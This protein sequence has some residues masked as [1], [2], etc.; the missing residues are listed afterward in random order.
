MAILPPMLQATQEDPPKRGH[1]ALHVLVAA[2]LSA[3]F[4]G[5]YQ[6]SS[7]YLCGTDPY[8]HV[9][10][11]QLIGEGGPILEFPWAQWSSWRDSFF[12]KEVLYHLY[13][14]LFVRGDMLAGAKVANVILGVGIFS[15]FMWILQKNRMRW[16]WLWWFL[17]LSSGG[18]FLFRMNVSRPQVFSVLIL[19][20]GLHVL[21]NERHYLVGALSLVYSL[22]YTGH[23]QYVGLCVG[24]AG[25]VY[26]MERRIPWRV[27]VFALGGM[28]LGWVVH[29]NFPHNV[30]GFWLQ[31]IQVIMAHWAP[32]VDLSMGGELNPMT[33]RS[34]LGVNGATLIP[35]WVAFS[36]ALLRRPQVTS[37]TAFLFAASTLYLIMTL[38]TKRFAEYWIPVTALFHASFYSSLMQGWDPVL[39]VVR[40]FQDRPLVGGLVAVLVFPP[41][42]LWALHIGLCRKG[43]WARL[44][45]LAKTG[46]VLAVV[47]LVVGL[48]GLFVASHLDSF[49]QVNRC[50]EP[51]YGPSAR[52]VRDKIPEGSQVLTCD[53]DDA[54]YL[55]FFSHRHRYTVFLDPNFMYAWR[56]EVWHR[57]NRLAHAKDPDPLGTLRDY[58]GAEYVYCT[59]DFGAFRGQLARSPGATQ[60]YPPAEAQA[61][62]QRCI[63]HRDC[64][65]CDGSQ[66]C[67]EGMICK[68]PGP[69]NK[70]EKR[71]PKRCE[72]D[73]HAY[74][75]QVKQ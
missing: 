36:L 28:L 15:L 22:S 75:F 13:L 45:S 41:N 12:D 46:G 2:I 66:D 62:H 7:T 30:S 64:R 55:F 9:K 20:G 67:P 61:L 71:Q 57:W 58:F 53:W 3:V 60:L 38:F 34:L 39:K 49:R 8:Y 26:L 52:F 6:F 1:L 11:S 24:Y 70:E 29:P 74:I 68:H 47:A 21:M 50:E 17:L 63:G 23:Y 37:R 43:R 5:Y 16:A 27:F 54:P 18:Y 73:P 33:T 19:L 25:V 31:N 35:L 10:L 56:P 42:A 44:Q 40:F 14:A 59:S 51:T 65:I 72:Q 32:K 48:G 69:P 4:F